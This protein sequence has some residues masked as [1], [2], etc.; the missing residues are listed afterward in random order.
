[1]YQFTQLFIYLFVLYVTCNN[2]A[3]QKNGPTEYISCVSFF[4]ETQLS[5]KNFEKILGY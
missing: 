3:K 2:K 5:S 4:K 1:M